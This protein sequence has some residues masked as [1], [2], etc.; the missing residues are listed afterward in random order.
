[1]RYRLNRRGEMV[2]EPEY[3]QKL[4]LEMPERPNDFINEASQVEFMSARELK[5]YI[6]QVKGGGK[7]LIRRLWV[8]YHYKVAVPFL[9]FIVM[10]IGAPLAMRPERGSPMLGVGTCLLVILMFYA[11]DSICLALGKGGYLPPFFAAWI[12]HIVFGIAGI[13]LIKKTA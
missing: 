11:M 5:K 13:Y 2:G 8:D 3:S 4:T 12:S 6:G 9:S 7:K 1:M 10:L